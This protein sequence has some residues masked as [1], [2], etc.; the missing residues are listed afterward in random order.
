MLYLHRDDFRRF[1]GL[2]PLAKQRIEDTAQKRSQSEIVTSELLLRTSFLYE[3]CRELEPD[4]VAKIASLFRKKKCATSGERIVL[5]GQRGG[6]QQNFEVSE[7]V[8][9]LDTDQQCHSPPPL[10]YSLTIT[11]CVNHW[12]MIRL[13]AY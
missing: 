12:R 10:V 7:D 6:G 13:A 2:C 11:D 4:V 9:A 1:L 5:E 8:L 3:T